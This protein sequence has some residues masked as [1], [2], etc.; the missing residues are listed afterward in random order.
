MCVVNIVNA[1][2]CF[3]SYNFVFYSVLSGL[4][5]HGN[6]LS[7]VSYGSETFNVKLCNDF[8]CSEKQDQVPW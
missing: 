6:I 8:V 1:M 5:L 2:P 3:V 4:V 7:A